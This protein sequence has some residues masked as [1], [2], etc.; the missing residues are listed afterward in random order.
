LLD[1]ERNAF[2][3]EPGYNGA[4]VWDVL[5]D[6]IIGMIVEEVVRADKHLGLMIPT[7]TIV[8]ALKGFAPRAYHTTPRIFGPDDLERLTVISADSQM[9]D[10]TGLYL[11]ELLQHTDDPAERYWIYITA[12]KIGADTCRTLIRQALRDETYEHARAGATHAAAILGLN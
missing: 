12:G 8:T 7:R 5:R 1:T 9:R 2:F 10:R 4:P 6:G 3:V 11:S